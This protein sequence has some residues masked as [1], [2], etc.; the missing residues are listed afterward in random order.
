MWCAVFAVPFIDASA[1]TKWL[2]AAALYGLSYLLFFGA[3]ALVGK[4]G[5]AA[6]K[7]QV[8][9]RF[10]PA[11]PDPAPPSVPGPPGS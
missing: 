3:V 7:E 11:A 10:R 9:A 6:L 4:E 8:K 2:A 1:E 5:Y